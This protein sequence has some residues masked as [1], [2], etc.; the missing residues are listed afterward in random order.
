MDLPPVSWIGSM[1]FLCVIQ[2]FMLI[3]R[4]EFN[5]KLVG[6]IDRHKLTERALRS[7]KQR[8]ELAAKGANDGLWDWDLKTHQ[9]Y[10]S[11]RWKIMLG[12]GDNDLTENPNEWFNLIHSEDVDEVKAAI[13]AH[14]R[15]ENP[16]FQCEFR[17]RHKDGSH[18]HVLSRGLAVKGVDGE[19]HRMA[20]SITD[21]SERKEHE[22]TLIYNTFHDHLTKLP[23]RHLFMDRVGHVLELSIRAGRK[24]E[25]SFVVMIMDIDK[26]KVVNDSMGHFFGDQLLVAIS[27][28][29]K[30]TIRQVDTIARIGGDEFA[31]L[32][33]GI[34][35][36]RE[37]PRCTN[38]LLAVMAKP[39]SIENKE[40]YVS[41]SIGVV[42]GAGEYIRPEDMWRDADIAMYYAKSKGG[43][44]LQNI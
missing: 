6:E 3:Q 43:G 5:L 12:Y 26:F 30:K 28:R 15:G 31:F 35:T 20:G 4:E 13:Q 17:M 39:F 24:D 7:S 11:P 23:N 10:F 2:L 19:Y 44:Q 40:V 32:F 41:A 14:L 9:V 21:I 1:A 25:N 34:K 27:Q 37:I 18:R 42:F 16:N 29:L 33:E 38:E 8:Y 36:T 22:E